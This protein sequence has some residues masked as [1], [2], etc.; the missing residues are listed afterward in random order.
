M[1]ICFLFELI[2]YVLRVWSDFE[3]HKKRDKILADPILGF[4]NAIK[5]NIC[6]FFLFNTFK[7]L[8]TCCC[9][10]PFTV[11]YVK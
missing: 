8:R 7:E 10:D 1:T 9:E 3:Q 11:I 6:N 4:L 5:Y 2:F